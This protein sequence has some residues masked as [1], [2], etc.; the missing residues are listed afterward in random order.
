MDSSEDKGDSLLGQILEG[1]YKVLERI[2]SGGMGVVYR[3]EHLLIG[4]PL[5]LKFMH[6]HLVANE[7]FLQRFEHEARIS[8][9]LK[10]PHAVLIYDYGVFEGRPYIV[11]EF[12]QGRSLK[13]VI[14]TQGP[15][16]PGRVCR[17]LEQAGAAIAEA[18]RLGII[19]RDLKPD[20]LLLH[21]NDEGTEQVSVLD[22]GI[23]KILFETT[24]Q[25]TLLTQSG[26]FFG[27][28][29]YAS[30]EQAL[31]HELDSR[32]DIYSLGAILYEMLSGQVPF[33]AP[34][35][36]EVL[37]KH[38]NSPPPSLRQLHPE[39][40]IPAAVEAVVLKCLEKDANLRF[41]S[42]SELCSAFSAAISDSPT[43]F[44]PTGNQRHLLPTIM[45]AFVLLLL[46]AAAIAIKWQSK[47]YSLEP[48]LELSSANKLLTSSILPQQAN[49]ELQA[50]LAPAVS[51]VA[52][53]ETQ[54]QAIEPLSVERMAQEAF[55]LYQDKRYEEAA[56][57]FEQSLTKNP[58]QL[59]QLLALSVCYLRLGRRPEARE[60]LFDALNFAPLASPVHFH[61]ACYYALGGNTDLAFRSLER[62]LQLDHLVKKTA[63]LEPDLV[64]LQNDPRFKQLLEKYQ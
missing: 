53:I 24:E 33:E 32:S 28:P 36:M 60:R 42:V 5:A 31:G 43:L 56:K 39:L 62:A 48:T 25:A 15:M 54:P 61:L 58:K 41:S 35:L 40:K 59:D 22:F 30:P 26:T 21:F 8:S 38:L 52:T 13:E 49:S 44:F 51:P 3:G 7:R 17:L 64:S 6:Q 57:L 11:M 37:L 34:S 63:L 29:R 46:I 47:D 23:A 12:I 4:R 55:R 10:H 9:R 27:T 2:G 45:I 20:N 18:H 14:A 16:E 19:H 1:K 50:P